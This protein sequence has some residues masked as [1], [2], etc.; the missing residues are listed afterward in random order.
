VRMEHGPTVEPTPEAGPQHQHEPA[1]HGCAQLSLPTLGDDEGPC[2][3]LP[4]GFFR[5]SPRERLFVEGVMKHGRYRQAALDAGYS[6][7]NAAWIA[8]DLVRR[9]DIQAVFMQL[10]HRAEERVTARAGDCLGK[11]ESYSFDLAL[12]KERRADAQRKVDESSDMVAR[13]IAEAELADARKEEDRLSRICSDW[14]KLAFLAMGKGLPESKVTNHTT[15]VTGGRVI[16]PALLEAITQA[17]LDGVL[18]SREAVP[19]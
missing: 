8:S 11:A 2:S 14:T 15:I 10:C 12:A 16:E 19:A 13:E 5:L 4:L 18:E 6:S 9:P 7:R 1:T 3:S 17:R